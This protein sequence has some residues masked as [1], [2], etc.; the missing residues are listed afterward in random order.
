MTLFE[1]ILRAASD[2][3]KSVFCVDMVATSNEFS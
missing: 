2:A 1:W 3:K